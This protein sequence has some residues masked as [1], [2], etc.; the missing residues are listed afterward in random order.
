LIQHPNE[1]D[2]N[3]VNENRHIIE[4]E[5]IPFMPND[6]MVL[7]MNYFLV[8]IRLKRIRHDLN[9]WELNQTLHFKNEERY[10]LRRWWYVSIRTCSCCFGKVCAGCSLCHTDWKCG[11][12]KA[13]SICNFILSHC[14]D[15]P[16]QPF[17]IGFVEDKDTSTSFTVGITPDVK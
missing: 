5:L 10:W 6:L 9:L 14:K 11:Q 2:G 17:R 3:D 12:P 8:P 1:W 16:R 4:N 15:V 7:V 13:A